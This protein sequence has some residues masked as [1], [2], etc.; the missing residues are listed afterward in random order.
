[1]VDS[2]ANGVVDAGDRTAVKTLVQLV[3]WSRV[4][5]IVAQPE[6]P[7]PE[8]SPT[9]W[10]EEYRNSSIDLI[11]AD[12]GTFE[13]R[14]LPSGDYSVWVWW[15]GGF[16][17]GATERLPDLYRAIIRVNTDGN[18]TAPSSLPSHWPE[19]YGGEPLD[20]VKDHVSVGSLPREILLGVPPKDTVPYPVGTGG[21]TL[22]FVGGRVDVGAVLGVGVARA[23]PPTGAA[24][25]DSLVYAVVAPALALAGM[26]SL[27]FAFAARARRKAR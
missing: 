23:L 19:S 15:A 5:P 8:F 9:P 1:V 22:S 10:P 3:I 6:G 27:A 17:D 20:P 14:N 2:N 24:E 25:R 4:A 18:I 21:T 26:G 7:D 12:G 16:V 13:F 11:T